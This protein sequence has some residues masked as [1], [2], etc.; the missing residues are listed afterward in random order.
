MRRNL[1]DQ[2][3]SQ[4][5]EH[6]QATSWRKLTSGK[7][8]S[9]EPTRIIRN[10]FVQSRTLW[11]RSRGTWNCAVRAVARGV[12]LPHTLNGIAHLKEA[13]VSLIGIC[14]LP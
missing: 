14:T 13:A 5:A 8:L 4:I 6:H 3:V 2:T 9:F 11:A 12:D 10:S 1:M 7:G